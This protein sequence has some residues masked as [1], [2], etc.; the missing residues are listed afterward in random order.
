MRGE[1]MPEQL[2]TALVGLLSLALG[3]VLYR[4]RKVLARGWARAEHE[5][6]HRFFRTVRVTVFFNPRL[7][8]AVV[9]AGA[10]AFILF[11]VYSLGVGVLQS[12]LLRQEGAVAPRVSPA[13]TVDWARCGPYCIGFG[14]PLA[15]LG[16]YILYNHVWVG[17]IL[18]FFLDPD[19]PVDTPYPEKPNGG[20]VPATPQWARI[21]RGIGL[22]A[23][24][25]G[26]TFA[27]V[28]FASLLLR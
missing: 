6:A 8:Q 19:L 10:V 16:T 22:L 2:A 25:I 7:W 28:G 15:V 3:A 23:L 17:R 14:L 5:K 27:I 24:A 26:G 13:K 4:G 1:L 9:T 11:G 21:A 12:V 18:R 20:S